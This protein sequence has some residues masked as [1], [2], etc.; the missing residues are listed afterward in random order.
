VVDTW[1]WGR[2]VVAAVALLLWPAL[3]A[4]A[5]AQP[6]EV[7]AGIY[8]IAIHAVDF[9]RGTIDATFWLWWVHN[10]PNFRPAQGFDLINARQLRVDASGEESRPDGSTYAYAKVTAT[11]SQNWDGKNVPFDRQFIDIV[12]E[13][14]DLDEQKVRLVPDV[15]ASRVD[16]E[17]RILGWTVEPLRVSADVYT[18]QSDFGLRDRAAPASYSR[19][20]AR[21]P[22]VRQGV[23]KLF[24]TY[25]GFLAAM[26][27]STLTYFVSVGLIQPR[28]TIAGAATFAAVG[29][30]YAVAREFALASGFTLS[31]KIEVTAFG[32]LCLA[33]V[34]TIACS[35]LCERG[36]QARA[37]AMNRVIGAA[38]AAL[39]FGFVLSGVLVALWDR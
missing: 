16:G 29:N 25:I 9:A 28:L 11:L 7:R 31:G 23:H 35:R 2:G 34:N 3:A 33:V 30:T 1:R 22:I 13:P 38:S 39:G 21:V 4:P 24:D 18:Y 32:L 17:I 5:A 10:L 12:I 27:L 19:L 14:L 6:V 36:Q 8:V 26:F 37:I 15:E 20:R